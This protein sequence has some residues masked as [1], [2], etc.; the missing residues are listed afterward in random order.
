M[1]YLAFFLILAGCSIIIFLAF[2]RLRFLHFCR[3]LEIRL[4]EKQ[5]SFTDLPFINTRLLRNI[6]RRLNGRK[7]A[8][9]YLATGD[10]RR[11]KRQLEA[12]DMPKEVAFL[13]TV[14]NRAHGRALW[15]K[16]YQNHPEDK[17]TR[18]M[19]AIFLLTEGKTAE[20][21]EMVQNIPEKKRESLLQAQK[22]YLMAQIYLQHADMASASQAAALAAG[23]FRKERAFTE[24]AYAYLLLG[25]IYRVSAVDDTAYFM[26]EQAQ[27]LFDVMR[28]FSGKADVLANLG[29][30]WVMKEKF[31]EAEKFFAESLWLNKRIRR[32]AAAAYVLTQA[33]LAALAQKKFKLVESRLALALKI[34]KRIGNDN[35]VALACEM[36]AFAA[37]ETG[38][39][40]KVIRFASIA[41]KIYEQ[42]G[43]F[44]A[45]FEC[46]YLQALAESESG[47]D[48]KAEKKLR[49][50]IEQAQQRPSCFYLGNAYNL[51]GLIFLRQNDLAR[52]KAIFMQS[53]AREQKDERF[54]AAAADYSNIGLIEYKSGNKEQALKTYQTAWTYASAFGDN[55]LSRFLKERIET[56]EAELK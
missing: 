13:E 46:L 18:I 53:A 12:L 48:Q 19:L 33:A 23:L 52:A 41:E 7:K 28:N 43:N 31:S 45:Y 26:F 30:L 38:A 39:Y 51:L 3:L 54:S 44:P 6:V 50:I 42:N 35:G 10:I 29:M 11:L 8:C 25:T 15:N 36:S 2:R 47:N 37:H 24:E 34:Q 5:L 1:E 17:D 22:Q 9:L 16:I 49:L 55:E 21:A 20:A 40:S 14:E 4:I 32:K 27:K 56:L